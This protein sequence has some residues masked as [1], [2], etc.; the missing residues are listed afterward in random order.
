MRNDRYDSKVDVYSFGIVLVAMMRAEKDIVTYF[1]EAL[2]KAMKKKNTLGIGINV[3]NNRMMNRDFRPILPMQLY[4]S[5]KALIEQCWSDNPEERPTFDEIVTR[6]SGA[7]ALEVNRMPEP[8]VTVEGESIL[9][10]SMTT[11]FDDDADQHHDDKNLMESWRT[12]EVERERANR[13]E[14]A[15]T[16]V[17]SRLSE[18]SAGAELDKKIS[19]I[20]RDLKQVQNKSFLSRR[21]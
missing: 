6:L 15:L 1:F 17:I 20:V 12:L 18:S 2:R 9:S 3:L 19:E 13:Y 10:L 14:E 21:E 4:P 11:H 8:D 5:L 7:I 16:S